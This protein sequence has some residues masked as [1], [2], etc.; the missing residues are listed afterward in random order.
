MRS[1]LRARA[2]LPGHTRGQPNKTEARYA[3]EVL[4]PRRLAG[5]VIR[6]EFEAFA[7]KFERGTWTPD[8]FV[9][10]ADQT[11]VMIDVKGTSPRD[12]EAQRFKIKL[13]AARWPE[14]R[15][16]IARAVRGGG[17]KHEEVKP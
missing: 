15:F 5:E 14:F 17:W 11:L 4:E 1:A 16:T 9:V 3:A 2:R 6:Y 7:I 8:Y 12:Q 13:A 10:M